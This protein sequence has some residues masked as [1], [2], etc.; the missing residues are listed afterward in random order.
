MGGKWVH[1]RWQSAL[2]AGMTLGAVILLM[3]ITDTEHPPAAAAGLGFA[4]QSLEFTLVM[5]FIAAVL[6]LAAGKIIFR[7]YIRDLD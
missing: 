2:A 3:S 7:A 4:L 6:T 1:V 5:L